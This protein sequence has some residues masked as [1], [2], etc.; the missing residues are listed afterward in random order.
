MFAQ[1]FLNLLSFKLI[2]FFQTQY[3]N[4]FLETELNRENSSEIINF[5]GFNPEIDAKNGVPVTQYSLL[6]ELSRG[7]IFHYNGEYF[8]F[9]EK[10]ELQ[11]VKNGVLINC[12]LITALSKNLNNVINASIK[13]YNYGF[14]NFT[15]FITSDYNSN[16]ELPNS[17]ITPTVVGV[18]QHRNFILRE[19]LSKCLDN[20]LYPN[21]P[22]TVYEPFN[23][24]PIENES[25][26]T[27]VE[28]IKTYLRSYKKTN[29]YLTKFQSKCES[30]F[31]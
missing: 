23:F 11:I 31:V 19:F 18:I 29:D 17:L 25:H 6:T 7:Q 16:S 28:R 2:A 27:Y 30:Y 14:Y 24:F 20:Y 9:V 5:Y 4:L 26:V 3:D 22:E 15:Q 8:I 13:T 12:Y 10:T 21:G 1:K